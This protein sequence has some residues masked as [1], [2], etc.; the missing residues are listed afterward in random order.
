MCDAL[1][2]RGEKVDHE[3]LAV[4]EVVSRAPEAAEL[5]TPFRA[6]PFIKS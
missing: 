1:E 3:A 5:F 2:K 6:R 4:L